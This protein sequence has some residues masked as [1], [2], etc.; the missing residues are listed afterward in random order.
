MFQPI[1]NKPDYPALERDVLAFWK[2]RGIFEKLVEKNREGE[3]YS[4]LDGPMTANNPMGVHHAWGRTYKDLFQ[5]Y[6][7]MRGFR[8]RYQN[9]FDCQGLWVEVE[10]E[11]DLGLNSKR[12]ILEYGLDRFAQKCKERVHRFAKIQEEQSV[13]LGQWMDWE[14]SYFT[15]TDTNIEHIWRFLKVCREK[16]WLYRGHRAMPWCCRCGTSLSQHELIDSYRELTHRSV[17]VRARLEDRPGKSILVWTTTPWTLAANVALAVHPYLNYVEAKQ[18]DES[19]Y[20]VEGRTDVLTPGHEI[21]G[22]VR[23]EDLVGLTYT[24]FF[25]DFEKQKF[26]HRVVPWEEVG[27]DEGTGIV[28]I[29]PGCGAEDFEL[30]RAEGLPVIVPIGED[31]VY[32]AGFGELSGKSIMGLAKEILA[33]LKREGTLY[34]AD[35][36]THRYPVCWR[37]KEELAFRV[38]DE[39]FIRCDEIREPMIEAAR[40]V[41]WIPDYMGKR[42]EDWLQNMGDW[43]ISRKRFWGLPLPIF[44]CPKCDTETIVGSRAELSELAVEGMEGLQELHRPWIDAVKIR[45]SKCSETVER[46][47]EVGDCWL[48]AGIVPFSTMRYLEDDAYWKTWFPAEFI[49]EMREQIRLWFYSMLFMSVTLENRAPYREVLVYEKVQDEHGKDMH[50]SAGNAIWF[51]DAVDKMGADVMRWLYTQQ[52]IQTNLRFGYGPAHEVKGRLLTYWNLLSFYVTYANLEKPECLGARPG[53]DDLSLLD[54]WILARL[55]SLVRDVTEAYETYDP[56]AIVREVEAFFEDLSNWYVRRS[57]RRYWKSESDSDKTCAYWTLGEVLDRLNRLI[58]PVLPFTAEH[59][60]QR[61]FRHRAPDAPESVFLC[62]FPESDPSWIDE[63]LLADTAAVQ[64]VVRLGHS[65]RATRNLKVRQPLAT[66]WVRPR[67]ASERAA[68]EA[69]REII[70]DELNIKSLEIVEAAGEYLTTSVRPNPK[71]LGPKLGK[72]LGAVKA[73]IERSDPDALAAAARGAGHVEVEVDGETIR[74][75][76]GDLYIDDIAREGYGAAK[77]GDTAV[78]VST[79]LTEA[80]L[81]EGMVRDLVRKIQDLRKKSGFDIADRIRIRFRASDAA[82][83]S[84]ERLRDYLMNE[85]LAVAVDRTAGELSGDRSGTFDVG[86]EAIAIA[87]EKA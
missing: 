52:N 33:K 28:H 62:P 71:M 24:P 61:V 77:E 65:A 53:R 57:R 47:P 74:I 18:G 44:I 12:E 43:C 2:E 68:I 31:G 49:T 39:W 45:C 76:A 48:D 73:A 23:G 35:D 72:K 83:A 59:V 22:Q 64:R 29:A 13:R 10:V 56:A 20:V 70:L 25:P 4:F 8:Q 58:A 36:Y 26:S 11:K 55:H 17:V 85:T 86:G 84:I 81:Q 6:K 54:R 1:D 19:F 82:S 30:G 7:A 60:H 27:A 87:L 75:E 9:G 37:C 46:I 67:D 63:K 21:V 16:G 41:R 50:K 15:Y 78:A 51:D 42:M 66:V 32:G 38:V 34:R 69:S 14:H 40:S 79:E 80:L 5:R 3:P